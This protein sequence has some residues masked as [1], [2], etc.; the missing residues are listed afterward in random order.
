M[1]V[2]ARCEAVADEIPPYQVGS[3]GC[4]LSGE[5]GWCWSGGRPG[6][7]GGFVLGTYRGKQWVTRSQV[8]QPNIGNPS[9]YLRETGPCET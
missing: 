4:L 9:L 8:D 5:W 7:V 3:G 6:V 2:D 1:K